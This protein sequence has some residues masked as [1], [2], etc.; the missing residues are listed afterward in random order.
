MPRE[1]RPRLSDVS[2]D[3]IVGQVM[4]VGKFCGNCNQPTTCILIDK[5]ALPEGLEPSTKLIGYEAFVPEG[6]LAARLKP[7]SLIGIGCGCYARFHR[8]VA[9]IQDRVTLRKKS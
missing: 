9:H 4:R 7:I 5:V 2:D 8:Q 6:S 3:L 1:K